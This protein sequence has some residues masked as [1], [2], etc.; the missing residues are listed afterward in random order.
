[1]KCVNLGGEVETVLAVMTVN[2]HE[3]ALIVTAGIMV[4]LFVLTLMGIVR[5]LNRKTMRIVD[6]SNQNGKLH[7]DGLSDEMRSLLL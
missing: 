6:E 2:N 4:V 7:V 3:V 5:L 1:M